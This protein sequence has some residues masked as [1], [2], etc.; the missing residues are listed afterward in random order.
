VDQKEAHCPAEFRS[1]TNQLLRMEFNSAGQ[2]ASRNEIAHPWSGGPVP[3]CARPTTSFTWNGLKD[4]PED[5]Q[6]AAGNTL[7]KESQWCG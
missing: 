6:L 2:W 7:G 5:T 1:I 3:P 4:T